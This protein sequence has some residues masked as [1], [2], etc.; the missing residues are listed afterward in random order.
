M[1][2]RM[3]PPGR[4]WFFFTVGGR[5]GNHHRMRAQ[6]QPSARVDTGTC[7]QV[8]ALVLTALLTAL[9]QRLSSNGSL[10]TA[11]ACRDGLGWW[12]RPSTT[13]KSR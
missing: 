11:P 8:R 13:G 12:G 6:D 5:M 7:L 2:D 9:L 3:L 4:C 10:L 1:L